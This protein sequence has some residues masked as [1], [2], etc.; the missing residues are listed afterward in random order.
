MRHAAIVLFALGRTAG[1][2]TS[3]D[4]LNDAHDATLS[5]LI[6]VTLFWLVCLCILAIYSPQYRN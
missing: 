5:F 4:N 3:P 6:I 1:A 2:S